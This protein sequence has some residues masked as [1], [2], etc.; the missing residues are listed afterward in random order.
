M[1]GP[2]V[3]LD[4]LVIRIQAA[5]RN[6]DE[7]SIG[8]MLDELGLEINPPRHNQLTTAALQY[9]SR[10]VGIPEKEL[11]DL[12]RYVKEGAPRELMR[13]A[14]EVG[15]WTHFE[16]MVSGGVIKKYPNEIR[17]ALVHILNFPGSS[18]EVMAEA[19]RAR[20]YIERTGL[21]YA[22][23]SDEYKQAMD[24]IQQGMKLVGQGYDILAKING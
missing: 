16:Y 22:D 11:R 1:V 12:H 4:S 5:Q 13:Q 7:F 9:V 20:G 21:S 3:D 2:D 18:E 14:R 17:E 24:L 6:G 15:R 8:L 19:R 10:K 23:E